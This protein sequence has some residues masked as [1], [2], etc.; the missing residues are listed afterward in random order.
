MD[1][2]G[3]QQAGGGTD[4][5]NG[6][7]LRCFEGPGKA[8]SSLVWAQGLRKASGLGPSGTEGGEA[9]PECCG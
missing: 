6:N 7:F 5:G 8:W 9:V 1:P 2:M 4:G 3:S